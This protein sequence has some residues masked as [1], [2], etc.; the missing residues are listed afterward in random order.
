MAGLP[1]V[2]RCAVVSVHRSAAMLGRRLVWATANT[3]TRVGSIIFVVEDVGKPPHA[4]SA[5][6]SQVGTS[7]VGGGREPLIHSQSKASSRGRITA[8][9]PAFRRPRFL[10]RQT[11]QD[12]DVW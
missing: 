6:R 1:Q 7:L 3:I 4:H 10:G 8:S 11:M 9:V 2:Q 12:D 5:I